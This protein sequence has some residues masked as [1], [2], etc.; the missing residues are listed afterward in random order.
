VLRRLLAA[1]AV[2]D[3]VVRVDPRDEQ[4]AMPLNHLGNPQTLHDVRPNANDVHA[5]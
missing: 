3:F 5:D 4:I 1:L 2:F